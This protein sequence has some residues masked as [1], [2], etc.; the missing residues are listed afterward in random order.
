M[1]HR[2]TYYGKLGYEDY[3]GRKATFPVPV[4]TK[5]MQRTGQISY[6]CLASI[7]IRIV[8]NFHDMS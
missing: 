6:T 2:D 8:E 5:D 3:T 4:F 1:K 7:L